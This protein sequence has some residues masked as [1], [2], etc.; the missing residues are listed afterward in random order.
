MYE[1]DTA[2]CPESCV[3]GD[4][5]PAVRLGQAWARAGKL[6]L[7]R[8]SVVS[9]NLQHLPITPS[10]S[11]YIHTAERGLNVTSVKV[12]SMGVLVVCICVSSQ[13]IRESS[14]NVKTRHFI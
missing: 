10:Y 14:L 12:K 6:I 5:C 2:A 13:R 8:V 3:M 9:C 11:R 1:L 7:S 4:C